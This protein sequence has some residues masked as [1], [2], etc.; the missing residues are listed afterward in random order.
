[1]AHG[2]FDLQGKVAIVTGATRGIGQGIAL[3]LAQAGAHIVCVG[4]SDDT[5]TRAGVE[6]LGRKYLNIRADM[7]QKESP[8]MIVRQTLEAFGRIDILVNAAGITRRA[9]AIDVTEEDWQDVLD[10]NL[11]AVFFM[12]QRVARQFI[13]QGGGGKIFLDRKSV[14]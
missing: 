7:A 5:V 9:M 10:V 8:D 11:T 3:G 13:K 1:M 6:Q 14:V 12:C 4:R 2:N